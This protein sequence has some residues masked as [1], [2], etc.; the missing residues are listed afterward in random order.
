MD[1]CVSLTFY[2]TQ[3]MNM[4][5][6]IGYNQGVEPANLSFVLLENWATQPNASYCVYRT[7]WP[8]H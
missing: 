3:V 2:R 1:A 6:C 8:L 5:I 7:L 4:C